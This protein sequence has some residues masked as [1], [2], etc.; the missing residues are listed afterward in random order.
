MVKNPTFAASCLLRYA[1]SVAASEDDCTKKAGLLDEKAFRSFI[2]SRLSVFVQDFDMAQ[3]L[4]P[5][6]DRITYI[7]VCQM[8]F[9]FNLYSFFIYNLSSTKTDVHFTPIVADRGTAA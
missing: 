8:L 5:G 6:R 2:D 4:I 7:H 9:S 3:K 1:L